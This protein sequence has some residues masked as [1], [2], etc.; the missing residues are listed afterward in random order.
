MAQ[1]ATGA[2]VQSLA[3]KLPHASAVA[4]KIFLEVRASLG[5]EYHYMYKSGR[6]GFATVKIKPIP[7]V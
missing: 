1:V 3:W 6:I 5:I 4:K 7:V 2:W